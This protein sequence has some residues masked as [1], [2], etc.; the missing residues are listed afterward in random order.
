MKTEQK[1]RA[2]RGVVFTRVN[3]KGVEYLALKIEVDGKDLYFKGF[4]NS[5]WDEVVHKERPKFILFES[6]NRPQPNRGS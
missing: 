1:M 6:E 4:L 5:G 2:E 3:D